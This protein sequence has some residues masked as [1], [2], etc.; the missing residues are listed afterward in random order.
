MRTLIRGKGGEDKGSRSCIVT[1]SN[2]GE[3]KFEKL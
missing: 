2:G 3:W 1:A